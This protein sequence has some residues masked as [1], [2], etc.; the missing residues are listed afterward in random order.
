MRAR[1]TNWGIAF[2]GLVGAV[3]LGSEWWGRDQQVDFAPAAPIAGP[4]RPART[5]PETG[6][7]F[8]DRAHDFGLDIVTQCGHPDKPSIL[9]ALGSGVALLDYD[10]D[11]DLD[12]AVTAGNDVKDD[13]VV[14]AGGP[15]LF[16][17]DGPGRW[18]DVS[19]ASGLRWTGWAQAIAVA[20]YDADGDLDLRERKN[21]H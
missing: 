17:N 7:W 20:D 19:A 12:I 4:P 6:P 8:V 18:T 16:R 3:L 11:G 5:R 21:E 13:K 14:P 15:W 10:G 2:L 1:S 9:H